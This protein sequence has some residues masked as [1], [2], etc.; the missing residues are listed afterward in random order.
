M[1]LTDEYLLVGLQRVCEETIIDTMDGAG[2][3]VILTN[4]NVMIPV[5][6][7]AAIRD[8]AKSVLLDE[9]EAV[10][11]QIPDI[12]ERISNVKG[13]MS[14]LF[15]FKMKKK[16]S[17]SSTSSRR[18]RKGS[19]VIDDA[20]SK[21]RVRFNISSTIY[22]EVSAIIHDESDSMIEPLSIYSNNSPPGELIND[23]IIGAA[24]STRSYSM[25]TVSERRNS[26]AH[27]SVQLGSSINGTSGN[28]TAGGQ[29]SENELEQDLEQENLSN[30]SPRVLFSRRPGSAGRS[31]LNFT[32]HHS[33]LRR[34]AS[35]RLEIEN[36]GASDPNNLHAGAASQSG[37]DA[38]SIRSARDNL[39]PSESL[40]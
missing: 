18:N 28:N 22:E 8:T 1:K 38:Q 19:I 35:Y 13:L 20:V 23:E 34:A 15:T 2:A 30:S 31:D 21:K 25:P 3:L 36:S 7:E 11:K 29:T 6:S 32:T 10:E 4:P 9:Y 5:N 26:E 12:E 14:D 40:I 24:S 33:S 17:G 37:H 39:N 16:K 27:I